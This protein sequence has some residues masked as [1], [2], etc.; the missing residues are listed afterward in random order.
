MGDDQR[1]GSRLPPD[2][3]HAKKYA[4]TTFWVRVHFRR[5]CTLAR[6]ET[7]PR[8][9]PEAK[10][11]YPHSKHS[12]SA[13]GISKSTI[14]LGEGGVHFISSPVL[15]S[16]RPPCGQSTP[17]SALTK[18][19]VAQRP[20]TRCKGRNNPSKTFRLFAGI[21]PFSPAFQYMSSFLCRGRTLWQER[22]CTKSSPY[23]CTPSSRECAAATPAA[24]FVY[25]RHHWFRYSWKPHL[26]CRLVMEVVVWSAAVE[27]SAIPVRV[28]LAQG[29]THA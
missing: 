11:L 8:P 2:G 20:T 24:L 15:R 3:K 14:N 13:S 23:R 22:W 5:A 9:K 21:I 18:S 4:L 28:G 10:V 6:L 29:S 7:S 26:L 16:F 1:A 17:T 19:W 12:G 27:T 25:P